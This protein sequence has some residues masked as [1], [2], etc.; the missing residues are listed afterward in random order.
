[1]SISPDVMNQVFSLPA[2][3]RYLLA[4]QLL[5]SIDDSTVSKFDEEFVAEL[6]RRHEEMMRGERIVKDW[7]QALSEIEASLSGSSE[8]D[9]P[10][11]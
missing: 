6:D 9:S 10:T 2:D 11:S 4:Q 8:V 3:E 5:D 1:M 7:R